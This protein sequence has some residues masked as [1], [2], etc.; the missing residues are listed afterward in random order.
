MKFPALK[1]LAGNLQADVF[2]LCQPSGRM[3]GSP[4]HVDAEQLLL[5]RL[6]EV[7]CKP[8]AND[9]FELPYVAEGFN[10]AGEICEH[11]FIN[12]IG[13]VPGTNRDLAPIL[14]GAHY[15]SVIAAPCAD[16]NGAA[17][18]ITL[19][20]AE[21]AAS[22]GGLERDL[23]VAIFDAEEPPYFCTP[24]M[25][26]IRFYEDQLDQ[27]GVQFA[28]IFDLVGHDVTFPAEYQP[29]LSDILGPVGS[30]AAQAMIKNFLF[31]MGSESNI[32]LPRIAATAAES[33]AITMLATLN[34]YV[35]DMSDHGVFRRNG[36]PYLFLSCGRWEH[37][38]RPTDTPEKL[39]YDKMALIAQLA[40]TILADTSKVTFSGTCDNDHSLEFEIQTL[41]QALGLALP[42]IQ[43]HL[44]MET[45]ETRS[46]IK[47][48]VDAITTLGI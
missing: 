31:V 24:S 3:V 37:Y 14:V 1:Q 16:D 29:I 27:R 17:V 15:D 32:E 40:A 8:Y 33:N 45:L 6:S 12:L 46:D 19:A 28:L 39:N 41:K 35:G 20:I 36:V 42:M 10:E 23:I 22:S 13:V 4:G 25:G 44:G 47:K 9:S 2:E 11:Q 18:A 43:Q 34:E 48:I 5:R 26:S 7:G 21:A 30:Q 38:H